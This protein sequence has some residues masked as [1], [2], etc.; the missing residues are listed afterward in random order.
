MSVQQNWK[1]KYGDAVSSFKGKSK[2]QLLKNGAFDRSML[3]ETVITLMQVCDSFMEEQNTGMVDVD[4]I[5]NACYKKTET[6]IK[7]L[8]PESH[9]SKKSAPSKKNEKKHVLLVSR[10]NDTEEPFN[11]SSW[12]DVVKN[13]ISTKLREV[14]VS[15]TVVSRGGEGVIFLPSEKSLTDAKNLLNS[16]FQVTESEKPR[17][18]FLPKM[19]IFDVD[20]NVD[21]DILREDILTKNPQ[22]KNKLSTNPRS[23]LEVLFIDQRTSSAVIKLTPDVREEI[24]LTGRIFSGM[25]DHNVKDHYYAMQCFKCQCFGHKQGSEVCPAKDNP[26]SCAYCAGAHNSRDCTNK[27]R[28]DRLK[29][30]NCARDS[31]SQVKSRAKGHSA[32]SRSCPLYLREIEKVKKLTCYDTK[33]FPTYVEN[34]P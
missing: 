15:S 8:L 27:Q 16:E 21:N 29:C 2:Q 25:T 13:S 17:R 32:T 34:S 28:V 20:A 31:N 5:A 11:E 10:N 14:P 22:L 3:I 18:E 24:N 12:A 7:K 26:P 30:A 9:E 33:N 6:L 4:A 19:K 23:R 1:T